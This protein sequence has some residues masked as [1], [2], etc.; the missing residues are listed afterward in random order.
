MA[1]YEATTG[2]LVIVWILIRPIVYRDNHTKFPPTLGAKGA[3]FRR[4]HNGRPIRMMLATHRYL[5]T[6]ALSSDKR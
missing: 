2:L 4:P 5:T 6:G 3:I 1:S